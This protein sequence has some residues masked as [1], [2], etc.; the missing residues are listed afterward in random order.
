MR[1]IL[2]TTL[3]CAV[4]YY[5]SCAVQGYPPGG[6]V[7][8]TPPFVVETFPKTDTTQVDR[9]VQVRILFNEPVE[10]ISCQ[11]SIFVTPFSA[12]A[13]EFKWKK[14]QELTI[15]F[16][17]SLVAD[18]TYIITIGAGTKDRQ[19]NA[20]AESYTLAFSTGD[21]LDRGKIG[22]TIYGKQVSGT[23]IWIYDLNENAEPDPRE[24]YPLYVTQAG[25]AGAF[26]FTHLASGLYRIFAVKDRDVNNQYDAMFDMIGISPRDVQLDSTDLVISD[27]NMRITMEDTLRPKL[28]SVRPFDQ[29]HLEL[30]FS[31]QMRSEGLTKANNYRLEQDGRQLDI[32]DAAM[33][34]QNAAIVFLATDAVLE[35]NSYTLC[36]HSGLDSSFQELMADS[37]CV[38][39][40]GD[41]VPDTN[42]P[43]YLTMVPHDSSENIRLDQSFNIFFSEAMDTSSIAAQLVVA[44]TLGDTIPGQLIWPDLSHCT[45][46][47]DSRY[48]PQ[49]Y[50]TITLPPDSVFDFFGNSLADTLFQRFFTTVN[51]DTF[52]AIAGRISDKNQQANGPFHIQAR[53]VSE[54]KGKPWEYKTVVESGNYE[55][56]DIM[57]GEYVIEVYRDEDRNGRYSLGHYLPYQPAERYYMYPDTIKVRANWPNDGENISFP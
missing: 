44:D 18:R 41:A 14:D 39:F 55:F 24:H 52:T 56:K 48:K 45:F 40:N 32:Y 38:S 37:S 50:Y 22:G 19:R 4:C 20:M 33:H 42:K 26:Q 34:T 51:P 12:E 46:Q 3:L 30:R 11:E 16:A 25:E 27:F 13:L 6:P 47:P 1:K 7:D 43:S 54:K 57:P 15:T 31:E 21:K 5:I 28:T 17:D 53:S 10:P 23:Q 36:A 29:N 2:Y 8:K 49:T 9:N 35:E